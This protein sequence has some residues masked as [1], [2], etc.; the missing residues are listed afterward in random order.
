MTTDEHVEQA[1]LFLAQA[2]AEFAAGD[3][4]QASEKLWGAASHAVMAVAQSE[5]MSCGSH[6]AQRAVA[7]KL[8]SRHC[9]P[10]IAAGFA[11]AG[12]FHANSCHGFMGPEDWLHESPLVRDF[13]ERVLASY[14]PTG[15]RDSSPRSSP[16]EEAVPK[17]GRVFFR[18][19]DGR[20]LR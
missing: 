18:Y 5:G 2:D 19:L 17:R 7:E 8:A 16:I 1:R 14:P 3:I 11:L 10:R 9:D 6:R 12:K 20:G 15:R 4:M 13:T